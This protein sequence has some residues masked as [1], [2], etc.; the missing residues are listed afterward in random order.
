MTLSTDQVIKEMGGPKVISREL[1][2]FSNRVQ[3]FEC[4]RAELT[5]QYPN[6]W[7][8]MYNED[9]VAV[10]DSLQDLLSRMDDRGVPRKEAIVEYMDTEQ[11]SMVL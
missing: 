4:K 11:R 2:E 5:A 7:I 8:A 6:K 3:V 1:R 10:A 9:I